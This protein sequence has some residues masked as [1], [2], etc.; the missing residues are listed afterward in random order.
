[1]KNKAICER[2]K[3]AREKSF[4]GWGGISRLS[5]LTGVSTGRLSEY[6]S[7]TVPGADKLAILLPALKCSAHW[8]LTGAGDPFGPE[9]VARIAEKPEG[10]LT[11]EAIR[12]TLPDGVGAGDVIEIHFRRKGKR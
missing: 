5:E 9:P 3:A 1:M 11:Q 10:Y 12:V 8:L 2:L 7:G 4:P 6:E